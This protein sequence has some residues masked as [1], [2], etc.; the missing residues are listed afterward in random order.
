MPSSSSEKKKMNESITTVSD[1]LFALNGES[2]NQ[3]LYLQHA[4]EPVLIEVLEIVKVLAKNKDQEPYI[5]LR[6]M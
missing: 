3:Q 6:C 1:M 5:V 4:E 2:P